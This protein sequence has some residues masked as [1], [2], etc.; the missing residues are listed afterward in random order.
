MYF[1]FTKLKNKPE[2][3]IQLQTSPVKCL[4]GDGEDVE[5]WPAHSFEHS[6]KVNSQTKMM[7][8]HEKAQ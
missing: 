5:S 2:L 6:N 3:F 1:R 4:S 8:G 7:E